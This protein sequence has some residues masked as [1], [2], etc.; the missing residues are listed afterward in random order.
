MEPRTL[1]IGHSPDADDAFMFYALTHGCLDTGPLRF[2]HELQDIETLNRRCLAGELD[3]SAVSLHAYAYLADRYLLLSSGCSMG[4]GYGPIVV[5]H[6]AMTRQELLQATIAIPGTLTTAYLVLRLWLGH[7]FRFTVLPFDQIL[8]AVAEGQTA[9][10]LLIHEGQL[11]YAQRG[12]HCAV[13][14][15]AWWQTQTGLPLPLGGNIVRKDLGPDLVQ[16]VDRYVR[17]SVEYALGHRAEALQYAL[18]FARGLGADQADR[19]VAMY[20]N[21]WTQD[22][23]ARGREA[24]RRLLAA[25]YQA[26]VLPQLVEPQFACS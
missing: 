24:V 9:A 17:A 14:L 8:D 15:G 7:P 25:G 19:F 3:V 12:L 23:G 18:R 20:V 2:R 4:D 1:T 16:L 13:D 10:G 26:G 21:Q 22:Y 11:T 5:T 6:Q